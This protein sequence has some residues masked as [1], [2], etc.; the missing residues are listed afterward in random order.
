MLFDQRLRELSWG[1]GGAF[2]ILLMIGTLH[3]FIYC[4]KYGSMVLGRN[5]GVMHG[6]LSSTVVLD[7]I[8]PCSYLLSGNGQHLDV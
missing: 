6:F 4:R 5:Y 7:G 1:R 8:K 3:D 2:Q